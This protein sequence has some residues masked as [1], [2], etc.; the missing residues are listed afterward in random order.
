MSLALN[1]I[2]LIFHIING[3]CVGWYYFIMIIILPIS[4]V[5]VIYLI[6]NNGI[7]RNNWASNMCQNCLGL[8]GNE[9]YFLKSYFL[10]SR[11]RQK[12]HIIHNWLPR[13]SNSS[14]SFMYVHIEFQNRKHHL[15]RHTYICTRTII[16]VYTEKKQ[17]TNA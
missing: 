12:T 4:S 16:L 5:W 8:S 10:C 13:K 11:E 14:F 15:E 1:T 7:S 6:L 2:C 17:F 3:H 9:M